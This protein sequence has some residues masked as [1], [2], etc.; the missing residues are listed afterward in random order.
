MGSIRSCLFKSDFHWWLVEE[1]NIT[2]PLLLPLVVNTPFTD[3]E[4][5]GM[6]PILWMQVL[7]PSPTCRF[8][9]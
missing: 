1:L 7:S 5:L 6:D 9:F 3:D 8:H 2:T 4:K